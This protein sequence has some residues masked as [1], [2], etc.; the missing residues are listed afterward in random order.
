MTSSPPRMN[1]ATNVVERALYFVFICVGMLLPCGIKVVF[2][3]M[4]MTCGKIQG[5][6][7]IWYWNREPST[8]I[9]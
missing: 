5:E 2:S 3:D 9:A 7:I 6:I 8:T 4:S 1:L